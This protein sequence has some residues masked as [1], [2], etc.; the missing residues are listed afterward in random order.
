M[1]V[2]E[3]LFFFTIHYNP[4]YIA[5][6]DLQN[7][8][9]NASVRSVLHPVVNK[10]EGSSEGREVGYRDAPHLKTKKKLT[11]PQHTLLFPSQRKWQFYA[12]IFLY[13]SLICIILLEI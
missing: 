1:G 3:K 2:Q 8:R 7:S 11:A 9:R 5:V 4:A 10:L 12:S 6:R 13:S